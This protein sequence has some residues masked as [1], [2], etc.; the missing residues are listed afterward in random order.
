MESLKNE[1]IIAPGE[2]MKP[3]QEASSLGVAIIAVLK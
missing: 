2:K 3:L 1:V